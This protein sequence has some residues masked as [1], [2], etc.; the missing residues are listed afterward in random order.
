[1]FCRKIE[2]H[3]VE[4]PTRR[5]TESNRRPRAKTDPGL[6]ALLHGIIAGRRDYRRLTR[7]LFHLSLLGKLGALALRRALRPAA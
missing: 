2:I 1:M 3:E 5:P 6:Y 4:F 7:E